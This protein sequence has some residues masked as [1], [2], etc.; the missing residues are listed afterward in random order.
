[1]L[2]VIAVA[3]STEKPSTDLHFSVDLL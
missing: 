2:L 3:E 1:M